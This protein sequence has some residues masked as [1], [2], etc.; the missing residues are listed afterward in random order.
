[1]G[2]GI[3]RRSALA[4][5]AG[6]P[7]LGAATAS[8]QGGKPIRIGF[9]HAMTGEWSTT[10]LYIKNGIY[11]ARD[12]WNAKG[13]INGRPILLIEED[14]ASKTAGAVTAYNKVID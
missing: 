2:N 4:L 11:M 8:A 13:G 14:D 10:S 1:M 6:L 5:I 3:S 7:L 9:I 12:E